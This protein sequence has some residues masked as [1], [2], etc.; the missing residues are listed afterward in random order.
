MIKI[1]LVDDQR[2]MCD[3]LKSMLETDADFTV[4]GMAYTG[5][6]ALELAKTY[7]PD[8]VLL[9]IRMPEMDGVEAVLRL[10][11]RFEDIKVVMLTTFNDEE[12]ILEAMTNGADGYLLKDMD[13]M[14]LLAAVHN[15][16]KGHMVMPAVVAENLKRG[17]VKIKHKKEAQGKLKDTGFT[18]REIEIAKL[19][20][21]GFSN[22]QIATA[23]YL[24]AG[25]VRNYISAIYE[26][27]GAPDK[28]IAV[29]RLKEMGL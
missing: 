21:D 7:R 29:A 18:N 8:L 2:L 1:L 3:G 24:S 26:K 14:D 12:Y 5:K 9:D 25:T 10:K 27:L 17:L 22:S 19:L 20:A 6:E 16:M 28:G 11:E 13:T 15:T 4:V 23:L